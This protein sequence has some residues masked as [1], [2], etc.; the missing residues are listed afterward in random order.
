MTA[1]ASSAELLKQVK[2]ITKEILSA[3]Q[4]IILFSQPFSN[5]KLSDL[6]KK[7]VKLYI[8]LIYLYAEKMLIKRLHILIEQICHKEPYFI[9]YILNTCY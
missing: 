4:N 7:I 5:G 9:Y 2:Q 6:K 8:T 1:N 3:Y